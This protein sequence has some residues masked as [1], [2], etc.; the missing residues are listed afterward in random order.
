LPGGRRRLARQESRRVAACENS[1]MRRDRVADLA[2]DEAMTVE[3]INS[4]ARGV[5][6]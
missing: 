3:W 4:G 1:A 5:E 2:N 6:K